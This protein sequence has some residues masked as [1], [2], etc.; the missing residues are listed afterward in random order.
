MARL[1]FV[2]DTGIYDCHRCDM[3][4]GV[5]ER[6]AVVAAV[7]EAGSPGIPSGLVC[8]RCLSSPLALAGLSA[9]G[10][11]IQHDLRVARDA[12]A[13]RDQFH[14]VRTGTLG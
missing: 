1:L 13:R 10:H 7:C 4:G 11:R 6:Q 12:K 3:C 5:G 8:D 9:G 14:V 2:L